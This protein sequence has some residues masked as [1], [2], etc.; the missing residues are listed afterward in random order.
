MSLVKWGFIGLILLPMLEIAAFVLAVLTIGWFWTV[1][2]FLATTVLGLLLLR[3]SG[4][5]DIERF[6]AALARDGVQAIHLES[7]GLGPMVAGI[8]LVIPGF[9]TDLAGAL[10]LVPAIRRALRAAF[11]RAAEARRRHRDPTVI[12]LTPKEWRQVSETSV[13][14]GRPRKHVR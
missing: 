10:L 1:C 3:R 9:I 13:E 2:L 6:R 5:A 14:D 4:R 7:P 11:G 8:L 12:D